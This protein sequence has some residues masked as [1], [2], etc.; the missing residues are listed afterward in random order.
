MSDTE[1]CVVLVTTPTREEAAALARELVRRHLAACVNVVGPVSSVYEWEGQLR[2]DPEWLM[3]VKSS[4]Q[5]LSALQQ[6]LEE[7]HSYEVPEVLALSVRSGSARYLEWVL[8]VTGQRT[9]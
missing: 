4:H 5:R 2:D 3:I 1:V 8:E 6:F 9:S 7:Q